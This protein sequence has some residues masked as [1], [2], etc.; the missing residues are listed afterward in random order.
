MKNLI[1]SLLI[2][3]FLIAF[4]IVGHKIFV[5]PYVS[6]WG[7][8]DVEFLA[9]MP[10]DDEADFIVST[11]AITINK[12]LDETWLWIN[13]LG[14]D[15]SGF[16]SYYFIEKAMGYYTRTQ[17]IVTADFPPFTTD[18]V[19]RGS[20][21]PKTSLI[22]YEFPVT[23]IKANEYFTLANWGTFQLKAINDQST[24]LIIRTHGK[25]RGGKIANTVDYIAYALHYIMERATINGFKHRI[26]TGVGA[27]F[28]DLADLLWFSFIVISG[29]LIGILIF[30]LRGFK[31]IFLPP[32]LSSLWLV[33]LFILPA[34]LINSGLLALILLMATFTHARRRNKS[35]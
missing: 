31:A 21:T 8:S 7:A 22:L 12:P 13:Q 32:I 33:T 24:R 9:T 14:A 34:S 11:R 25:D 29:L 20:I 19:V 2:I 35:L 16:F 10:H 5:N 27:R 6:Q 17:D 3:I 4:Q 28:S 23:H 30:I 15:R 18:D 26:E 1:K